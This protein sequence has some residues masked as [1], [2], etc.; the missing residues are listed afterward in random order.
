MQFS[1]S[2]ASRKSSC[3]RPGFLSRCQLDILTPVG[4]TFDIAGYMQVL[5]F[6]QTEALS[7]YRWKTIW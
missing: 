3:H 6:V 1:I 2:P 4:D 7:D 5:L